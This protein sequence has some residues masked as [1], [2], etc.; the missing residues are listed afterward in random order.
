MCKVIAIANQKGGV[1]KTS[2]TANLGVGLASQGK[3]VLLV[4]ADP[5]GSLTKSLGYQTRDDIIRGT[6]A[7]V[8]D[9]IINN[10]D[11]LDCL[12]HHKENITLLP[13]DKDLEDIETQLVI[14]LHRE[15]RLKKYI[16]SVRADYDYI[17]I[18]CMPSLGLV[19]INAL[20][21]A[22]SVIVPLQAQF[23]SLKGL[24]QLIE[25]INS[26]RDEGLNPYLTIDGLLLTMV[27]LRTV[28]TRQI[29]DKLIS[30]YGQ[31]LHIFQ[32]YIPHSIRAAETSA[33]G[34][35][36]FLYD[37]K[38]KVAKAYRD[39]TKEVLAYA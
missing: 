30:Y 15:F 33:N 31:Y 12:L 3:K 24:E 1:G 20:V 2:L 35:S 21:A 25:T 26:L 23:L 27:N 5:Q 11:I 17:L 19:T 39:L 22:D 7:S 4:D 36:I 34:T 18:D 16:D 6:L 32:T 13:S 28:H 10:R 8:L 14:T 38:G 37:P 9:S 29:I